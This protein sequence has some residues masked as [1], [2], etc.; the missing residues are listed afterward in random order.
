MVKVVFCPDDADLDVIAVHE[1]LSDDAKLWADQGD[2]S[3]QVSWFDHTL[4]EYFPKARLCIWGYDPKSDQPRLSVDG[5]NEAAKKF[6]EDVTSLRFGDHF[7]DIYS[8]WA[9]VS[10]FETTGEG[11]DEPI[12]SRDFGSLGWLSEVQLGRNRNH[13]NI[14]KA[15][16][17]D[18]LMKK[19]LQNVA[20]RIEDTFVGYMK[21]LHSGSPMPYLPAPTSG[22]CDI[23]LQDHQFMH[24]RDDLSSSIIAINTPPN[25][26]RFTLSRL[27]FQHL[28]SNSAEQ[29][30]TYFTF[31]SEN[32]L[33]SSDTSLVTSMTWQVLAKAPSQFQ[34]MRDIYNVEADTFEWMKEDSWSLFRT[35]IRSYHGKLIAIING[36]DDANGR[37]G[38]LIKNLLALAKS[39]ISGRVKFLLTTT[40]TPDVIS[41]LPGC[42]K[43]EL[44]D[45]I[46]A[47]GELESF[48]MRSVD[49]YCQGYPALREILE[50]VK[51]KCRSCKN[52]TEANLFLQQLDRVRFYSSRC[53]ML[54]DI[55]SFK[56]SLEEWIDTMLDRDLPQW[57]PTALSWILYGVRPLTKKELAIAIALGSTNETKVSNSLSKIDDDIHLDIARDLDR[58][59]GSL[60]RARNK[61]VRLVNTSAKEYIL[62]KIRRGTPKHSKASFLDEWSIMNKCLLYLSTTE[63]RE[64]SQE[65]SAR[66]RSETL[67][68]QRYRRLD[69]VRYAVRC[70]PI[71]YRRLRKTDERSKNVLR[72]LED[73]EFMKCLVN[74]SG[75]FDD[76]DVLHEISALGPLH[77]AARFGFSDIVKRLL[78][79][80]TPNTIGE[81]ELI[82]ALQLASRYGHIDTVRLLKNGTESEHAVMKALEV[83]CAVGFF[84]IVKDLIK[85]LQSKPDR[86]CKYPSALLN[87]AAK[88]G[89]FSIVKVLL[90]AGADVNGTDEQG[91]TALHLAAVQGNKEIVKLLL[92]NEA[93]SVIQNRE[94]YTAQHLAAK[95]GDTDLVKDLHGDA[96]WALVSTGTGVTPL[97]SASE[98]GHEPVVR[99][100][101][102][103]GAEVDTTRAD[104]KTALLLATI[105]G[106]RSV[107]DLLLDR[108]AN[109]NHQ[110]KAGLTA[111]WWAL[112]EEED[113]IAV[114]LFKRNAS[115]NIDSEEEWSPFIQAVQNGN[116][117][118][119]KLM[120]SRDTGLGDKD[121]HGWTPVQYAIQQ[122]HNEIVKLL[123]GHGVK[124]NEVKSYRV[125]PLHLAVES[126]N[127]EIVK[128]MLE[129]GADVGSR[130]EENQTALHIATKGRDKDIM[131]LLL[132]KQAPV[133]AT[134][135]FGNAAIHLAVDTADL[136]AVNLLL[137]N[138][139]DMME[140][141]DDDEMPIVSALKR[142]LVDIA[143]ALVEHGADLSTLTSSSDTPM[144]EAARA[145]QMESLAF[146]KDQ[147]VHVDVRSRNRRTPLFYA[148]DQIAQWLL[149]RGASPNASD[150][151]GMTALMYLASHGDMKSVGVLLNHD[152]IDVSA[153]DLS[154]STVLHYAAAAGSSE[155]IHLLAPTK[156]DVNAATS[157]GQT[158][159]MEAVRQSSKVAVDALLELNADP[160]LVDSRD[161][162]A[163]SMAVNMRDVN[164]DIV[165]SLLKARADPTI[166]DDMGRTTLHDA[167]ECFDDSIFGLIIN[168]SMVPVDLDSSDDQGRTGL[169]IAA[170][171]NKQRHVSMLLAF[172]TKRC[173]PWIRDK[174]Q[175]TLIH[176]VVTQYAVHDLYDLVTKQLKL[177]GKKPKELGEPDKDGW[178]PLHWA[179]KSGK[180]ATVRLLCQAGA[181]PD[182]KCTRGWTPREV[183]IYHNR[184]DLV[185]PFKDDLIMSPI[186]SNSTNAEL[187]SLIEGFSPLSR[188]STGK[189]S[190]TI[191][192]QP[193][194]TK[195]GERRPGVVCDGC[196][197][198]VYGIQFHCTVCPNF[199]FCYKCAWTK[200]ETHRSAHTFTKI[201]SGYEVGP[202]IWTEDQE[203]RRRMINSQLEEGLSGTA[204]TLRDIGESVD[205]TK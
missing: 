117:E 77:F 177:R 78:T 104:G 133:N 53:L 62:Q 87:K 94:D 50:E 89:H 84:D 102:D 112:E 111:L 14:C 186:E 129:S 31:D 81:E 83:P 205:V 5:V 9:I 75:Q 17:G 152:G 201:G 192:E 171:R 199:D 158:P 134:D 107:I 45:E 96:T 108:Q 168:G 181:N 86:K 189:T 39:N 154:R 23:V 8:W 64:L 100:F 196:L 125:S 101:L 20:L 95:W 159:L 174:Q 172:D 180:V 35:A 151:L 92:K 4:P 156:I 82:Q 57:A 15:N 44:T 114:V 59:F 60:I 21:I 145:G 175:R 16:T 160:N 173:N 143:R 10:V 179:C 24:W 170:S 198:E 124:V 138:G 79:S 141:D 32:V 195:P 58:V 6:L 71:H 185:L 91:N 167:V 128:L 116:V 113:D 88:G 36:A 103:L 148:H 146:L 187:P 69:M 140:E 37:L 33:Q 46:K 48:M 163:L 25:S 29:D 118:L 178:S 26:G 106:H 56:N 51:E 142:G 1:L 131:A 13:A 183:A 52:F 204:N 184:R 135:A 121:D 98:E 28:R 122:G 90:G 41:A 68:D 155:I 76:S 130:D 166:K 70:W 7:R 127:A 162:T 97:H 202:D 80:S 22:D 194:A 149:E 109:V 72:Y 169:H 99:Y 110:D 153:K 49:K 147:G 93:S 30:V 126:R 115:P 150:S 2:Y 193:I 137:D 40:T 12:V 188:A 66:K 3:G 38:D 123:I 165:T 120:L 190:A 176:N 182:L 11:A 27:L 67:Q 191:T 61:E 144:H 43:V 119:C 18:Q 136:E 139:A 74:L 105:N 161:S 63:I 54:G 42:F 197:T 164:V 47:R 73:L 203:A 55:A 34:K 85:K 157:S 65:S 19:I 200:E 132:N